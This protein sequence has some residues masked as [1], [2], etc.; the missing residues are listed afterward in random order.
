MRLL[1]LSA[2][3][4][5]L[6]EQIDSEFSSSL[7]SRPAQTALPLQ[8]QLPVQRPVLYSLGNMFRHDIAAAGKVR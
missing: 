5:P 7:T 8:V 3:P 6:K 2:G 4:K 1:Y